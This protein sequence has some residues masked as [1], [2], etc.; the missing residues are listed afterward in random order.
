MAVGIQNCQAQSK[1]QLQLGWVSFDFEIAG[2]EPELGKSQPNFVEMIEIVVVE[3][4]PTKAMILMIP[5]KSV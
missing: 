1:F 3:K 4:M 5:K 2:N